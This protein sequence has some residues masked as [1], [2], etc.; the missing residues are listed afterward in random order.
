MDP[1]KFKELKLELNSTLRKEYEG[2]VKRNN[3][4]S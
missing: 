2:M 4:K 3:E 1:Q